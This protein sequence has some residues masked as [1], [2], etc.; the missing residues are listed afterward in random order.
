MSKRKLRFSQTNWTILFILV[1]IF[2]YNILN[3][4]TLTFTNLNQES[5]RSNFSE[6]QFESPGNNFGWGIF[7]LTTKS[8]DT[9]KEIT[10][11]SESRICH[12]QLR[13]IYYNAA[14]WSRLRPLDEETLELLKNSWIWY[15]NLNINDDW[16]F[17]TSCE[18]ENNQY[19]I[20][21][22]IEYNRLWTVTHLIAW[23]KL[24]YDTNSYQQSFANN[25][26]YFN[27]ITPLWYFWDSVGWIWFI[28]W[29]ISWS[30]NLLDFLNNS[31]SISSSFNTSGGTVWSDWT[32]S[33]TPSSWSAQ[34]TMWNIMVQ[35]NV[36][37][38]KAIDVYE[39][40][41]FLGNLEKR[42]ILINSDINS[43]TI[44]NLA[45]KNAEILC[46]GRTFIES[47]NSITLPNNN[48]NIL[49]YKNTNDLYIDLSQPNLYKDK[50]IVV[51]NGNVTLRNTMTENNPALDI[52]IDEGHLYV[53]N[54]PSTKTNFNQDGYPSDTTVTNSWI[55]IKGNFVVNWLLLGW[56]PWSETQIDHKLHLLGKIAF[57][58]TPTNPS[59]W[60]ILQINNI[61]GSSIYNWRIS[62]ENVFAWNCEFD[63]SASDW[64]NCWWDTSASITPFVVLNANYP[65]NII[66]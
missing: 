59:D 63:W 37:L 36:I 52:F 25:I 38:S 16:W 11:W 41:A 51:K 47:S 31:W 35:G 58:N 5:L 61:F 46:R 32:W 45:K 43:A 19:A 60:R 39:K 40:K 66:K 53:Q 57:L 65:S 1:G 26:E 54:N 9:P 7:R 34:D 2:V 24:D 44:I 6:I 22:Y 48:E 56:M 64:T 21:G 27:N 17:Y 4:L 15:S 8:L 10:L 55:F 13:W 33:I 12:K 62:L 28:W 18:G 23:T 20:Y 30:S 50:T 14:R 3:W 42:T 49:C 29:A